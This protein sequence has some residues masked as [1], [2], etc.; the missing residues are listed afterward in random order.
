MRKEEVLDLA[1]NHP[2][3]FKRAID[4]EDRA[5]AGGKLNRVKGLGRHWSWR[6]LAG[7]DDT[8]RQAL[9]EVTCDTDCACFDG[10]ED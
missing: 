2:L 6:D 9:P 7:A 8:A 10:E 5:L 4:L 3:L 1:T